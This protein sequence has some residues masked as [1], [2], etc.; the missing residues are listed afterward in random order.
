MGNTLCNTY[1]QY[2]F[3]IHF[4]LHIS[5]SSLILLLPTVLHKPPVFENIVQIHAGISRKI[6]TLKTITELI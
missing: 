3:T 5:V 1:L 4:K 2:L 6:V